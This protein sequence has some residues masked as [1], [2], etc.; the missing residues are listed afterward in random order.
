MKEDRGEGEGREF[1]L[2][3]IK[4][5]SRLNFVIQAYSVLVFN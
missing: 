5:D 3:V 1:E 2:S 4:L